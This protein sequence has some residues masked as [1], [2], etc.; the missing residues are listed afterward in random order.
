MKTRKEPRAGEHPDGLRKAKK[1]EPLHR[2]GKER[3]ALY[4]RYSEEEDAD[5]DLEPR[6]RRESALDYFDD[7]EA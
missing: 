7:E 5:A 6:A 3:H 4:T 2:S 1:L